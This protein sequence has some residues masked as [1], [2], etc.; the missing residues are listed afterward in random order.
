MNILLLVFA[1]VALQGCASVNEG[2]NYGFDAR[3]GMQEDSITNT[4][5]N[6]MDSPD[7]S[8]D[9]NANVRVWGATY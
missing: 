8:R 9:P 1:M 6:L 5:Y 2:N 4:K 7:G 3:P